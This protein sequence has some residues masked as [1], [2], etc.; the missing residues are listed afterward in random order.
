MSG[1]GRDM[2]MSWRLNKFMLSPSNEKRVTGTD[3]H[4]LVG[5]GPQFNR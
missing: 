2:L 3:H 4:R 5:L 1:S